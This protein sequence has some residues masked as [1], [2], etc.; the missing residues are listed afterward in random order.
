MAA[1]HPGV[2][3]IQEWWGLDGHIRDIAERYAREGFVAL[4][5]DMY[6]GKFAT[7]PDE[8]RKLVMSMNREQANKDLMGAVKFLQSLA[9]G[10]AE[11]GRR[12][13][14]LHGRG[15]DAV[16]GDGFHRRSRRRRRSTRGFGRVPTTWRRSRRRCSAPSARTTA[17]SRSTP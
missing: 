2:I 4:A 8:A 16:A 14:F 6:H 12:D 10:F 3:V 9:V 17:A 15:A 13:G 7:E 1:T 5:P 11:E